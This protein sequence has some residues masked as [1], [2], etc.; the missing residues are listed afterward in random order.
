M[1]KVYQIYDPI[2]KIYKKFVVSTGL[3]ELEAQEFKQKILRHDNRK[4]REV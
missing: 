3:E 4:K 2:K 1:V